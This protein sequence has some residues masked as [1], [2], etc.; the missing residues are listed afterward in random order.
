MDDTIVEGMRRTHNRRCT[1]ARRGIAAATASTAAASATR[2]RCKVLPDTANE[3]A[4]EIAVPRG[5]AEFHH[6]HAHM[7]LESAPSASHQFSMADRDRGTSHERSRR[8]FFACVWVCLLDN[9]W[10]THNVLVL[11]S[12]KS[13]AQLCASAIREVWT[14]WTLCEYCAGPRTLNHGRPIPATSDPVWAQVGRRES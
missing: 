11:R 3:P 5:L 12:H 7:A 10:R 14:V 6:Q 8:A 4:G 13:F 9:C 1:V 2:R